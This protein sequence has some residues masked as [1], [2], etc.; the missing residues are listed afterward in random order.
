MANSHKKP[1]EYHQ[2]IFFRVNSS[3]INKYLEQKTES[4]GPYV[5]LALKL[6]PFGSKLKYC[7]NWKKKN[8]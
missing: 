4:I 3:N 2:L 5:P 1:L 7:Q 8:E 6:R